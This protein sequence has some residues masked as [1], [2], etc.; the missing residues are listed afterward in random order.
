[1]YTC[2]ECGR[3][4]GSLSG[5]DQHQVWIK[6]GFGPAPDDRFLECW[7][8]AELGMRLNGRGV[9]VQIVDRPFPRPGGENERV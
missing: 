8:P 3:R 1:M 9:W 6:I 4:F 7:D 5:F 2:A